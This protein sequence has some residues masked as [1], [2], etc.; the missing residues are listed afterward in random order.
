MKKML[1]IGFFII[2][3][4]MISPASGVTQSQTVIKNPGIYVSETSAF[5]PDSLDPATNYETQGGSMLEN[6]Y[7][8]LLDYS[9]NSVSTYKPLLALN[10]TVSPDGK[11]YTFN[12]RQ[13]VTFSDGQPFNAYVMK[14]SIDRANLI[15]D[16][17]SGAW[18]TQ[19]VVAGGSNLTNTG[20]INVTQG[21]QYLNK[22]GIVVVSD[23]VLNIT[24]DFAAGAFLS[25]IIFRSAS[26]IS[27]KAVIDNEPA[28]Y[29]TNQADDQF[30]MISLTD[31]FP[32]LDNATILSKLGLPSNYDPGNSGI[33]PQGDTLT[34]AS[35]AQHVWLATHSA[36]TGPYM[37][38]SVTQGVEGRMVKNVN[39]W[40]AANFNPKSVNTVIIK[41]VAET[42]T[43]VLDLKN[44]NADSGGIPNSNLGELMN[45]T[46]REPLFSNLAVY[47][48]PTF[49]T[50]AVFF[51][52]NDTLINGQVLENTATSNYGVNGMNY[53]RLLKYSWLDAGGNPQ[54]ASKYNPMTSLLFRKAMAYS[55]D[56]NA[57]LKNV[58]SGFGTRLSG[59]IPNGFLGHMSDLITNG[60][61]PS[62]DPATAKAL[63]NEVGFKGQITITYNTGSTG[64]QQTAQLF[65]QGIES[66][67][68]GI[69]VFIS[70]VVWNTFLDQTF[71]GQT[72]VFQLGWAPDYP[73]PDNYAVPYLQSSGLFGY[74]MQYNNTH[75]DSLIKQAG[76]ESDPATRALLYNQIEINSTG[77]YP[78][79][80]LSQG[81]AVVVRAKWIT[82]IDVETNGAL[83]PMKNGLPFQFLG[84]DDTVVTELPTV[85]SSATSANTTV[86]TTT[87]PTSSTTSEGGQSPGFEL[88]SIFGILSVAAI[89][90][91]RRR[92]N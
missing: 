40:N 34:G 44:G 69:S 39:W 64:R 4:F 18:I 41:Q 57:Y 37:L 65:K 77:D 74:S 35:A 86:T 89:V 38:D 83:N 15:N 3:A 19:Q 67:G 22:G 32:S 66:L 72:G 58:L 75:V 52:F 1:Y 79:I 11:T 10:Y 85:T 46:T 84:K 14:Y 9:G 47:S 59:T 42:S 76:M 54:Y 55:F 50:Q 30:G 88:V 8:T 21:I 20:D 36:G 91:Q 60:N 26:A 62:Y 92:K 78:M 12:L 63:F 31:M 48:F 16:H 24:Q 5:N 28:A 33:V 25:E 82:G 17:G 2:I 43:R 29:T 51:N 81:E 45:L 49:T 73:D 56:Y 53:T 6:V 13:G 27:P 71:G 68:V 87:P 70:D 61:I 23:Y 80:Y 7:E 90:V